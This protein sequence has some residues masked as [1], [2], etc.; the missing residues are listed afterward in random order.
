MSVLLCVTDSDEVRSS[1]AYQTQPSLNPCAFIEG[2]VRIFLVVGT[3]YRYLSP[4]S[5]I[6]LIIAANSNYFLLKVLYCHNRVH[7]VG[8]HLQVTSILRNRF[9]VTPLQTDR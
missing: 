6:L 8:E 1:E 9:N 5:R 2:P 3:S 7:L 4:P